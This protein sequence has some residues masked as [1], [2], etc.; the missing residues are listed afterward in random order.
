MYIHTHL[1]QKYINISC[2]KITAVFKELCVHLWLDCWHCSHIQ[3]TVKPL[4][5]GCQLGFQIHQEGL[6]AGV[7]SDASCAV[8]LFIIIIIIM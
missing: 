4:S 2:S 7:A 6:E 1:A 8:C 3:D 5:R